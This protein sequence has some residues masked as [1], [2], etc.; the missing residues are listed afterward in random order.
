MSRLTFMLYL[1]YTLTSVSGLALIKSWLP[2]VIS[3]RAAGELAWSSTALFG[4]GVLL[5]I[6][7]FGLWMIILLRN[8]LSTAYPV[9]I[10]LTL[11]FT[12]IVAATLLHETI[13]VEKLLGISLILAGIV[14]I[15]SKSL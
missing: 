14:L 8:P 1:V 11:I 9:A 12:T 4:M 3:T 10:G 7:S 13:S 2:V 15:F 6:S 5:Y